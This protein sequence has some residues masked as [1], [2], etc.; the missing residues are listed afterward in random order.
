MSKDLLKLDLQ[1]C[2]RIYAVGN[3][4]TRHYRPLLDKLD[5]TY[6]QYVIMMALWESDNLALND[7]VQRAKMDM[8]SVSLIV[9][10]LLEKSYIQFR[11]DKEDKRKKLIL[12]TAKG[13]KLK[14]RAQA[15]PI[16]M[17]CKLKQL[18]EREVEK[19]RLLLDRFYED[20]H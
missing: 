12:L 6:P 7:L 10:R 16:E 8:G 20:F 14:D 17:G 4:L 5:L 9:K 15:V 18:D 11:S 1:I 19:L 3:A 13:R 2:H